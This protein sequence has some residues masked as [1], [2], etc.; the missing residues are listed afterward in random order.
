MTMQ[1]TDISRAVV[2][3]IV[4][5]PKYCQK[6]LVNEVDRKWLV[7]FSNKF[8]WIETG[9]SSHS[10]VWLVSHQ[11]LIH[12]C[13]V[14]IGGCSQQSYCCCFVS[15]Q[16]SPFRKRMTLLKLVP[17]SE[18]CSYDIIGWIEKRRIEPSRSP[19]KIF[20]KCAEIDTS[21]SK[22]MRFRNGEYCKWISSSVC[23]KHSLFIYAAVAQTKHVKRTIV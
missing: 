12:A 21:L 17:I 8:E 7:F 10:T 22:V 2:R 6:I 14:W 9:W 4:C 18:Q 20:R 23:R 16:Y 11:F 13:G 3:C 19:M 1:M 15:L 5:P